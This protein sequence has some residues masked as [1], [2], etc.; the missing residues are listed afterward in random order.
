MSEF[1]LY[2]KLGFGHVLDWSAYDHVLFLIVLTLGYTF[3][4]WKRI[5]I[6]ISLFTLGHT[7]SLF[8]AS[9]NVLSVNSRLVEFLIPLT[10]LVTAIFN[11]F[12]AG[13]GS[14][15]NKNGVL[16]AATVFFGLIHGLGF[17]IY[18]KHVSGGAKFV[19]LIE[20]ALGIELAQIIVV[21]LIIIIGFLSKTFFRFSKRD[22]ILVVS[23][24]VI[25][26]VIP[27]LVANK[28]W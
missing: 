19:S 3:D 26:L 9:F 18:F 23:S 1:W 24:I 20:F 27:M 6:L 12:T 16:Y 15:V 4:H 14:R 11:L 5:L 13:K 28:I 22:W 8:L 17:S 7:V 10:I 25:G 21:T 2:V